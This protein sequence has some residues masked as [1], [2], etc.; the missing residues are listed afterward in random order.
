MNIKYKYHNLENFSYRKEAQ[1]T[2]LRQPRAGCLMVTN[3]VGGAIRRTR[4]EKKK[5]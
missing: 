2:D 5:I 1:V 4:D 3:D